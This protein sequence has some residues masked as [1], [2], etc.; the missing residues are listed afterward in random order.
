MENRVTRTMLLP[1][2]H[3]WTATGQ[4]IYN[5]K[6]KTGFGCRCVAR[7]SRHT[8]RCLSSADTP[9]FQSLPHALRQ[10]SCEHPFRVEAWARDVPLPQPYGKALL[11]MSPST[12]LVSYLDSTLGPLWPHS[13][14]EAPR[15]SRDSVTPSPL[16]APFQ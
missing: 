9:M 8:C 4:E 11:P 15:S 2:V 3:I 12:T 7:S 5:L 10:H 16:A 14:P 1:F 6:R 13:H